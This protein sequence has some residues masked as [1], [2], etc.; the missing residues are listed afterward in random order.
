M[1][2]GSVWPCDVLMHQLSWSHH[3]QWVKKKLYCNILQLK[4]VFLNMFVLTCIFNNL[5]NH[6]DYDVFSHLYSNLLINIPT[7]YRNKNIVPDN[8]AIAIETF[9]HKVSMHFYHFIE[10]CPESI[11]SLLF[12]ACQI[13]YLPLNFQPMK[14]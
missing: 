13:R 8:Y 11:K 5:P 4:V 10:H 6:A 14:K 7:F 3:V 9:L 1:L 12:L 2:K